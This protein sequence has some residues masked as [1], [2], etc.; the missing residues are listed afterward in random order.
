MTSDYDASSPPE[1]GPAELK[2]LRPQV[3][4]CWTGPTGS[5]AERAKIA[6]LQFFY[7]DSFNIK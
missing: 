3:C 7:K 4:L 6:P 5:S 1:G 2:A